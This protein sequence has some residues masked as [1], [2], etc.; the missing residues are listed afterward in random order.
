M[1]N[2][3][4]SSVVQEFEEHEKKERVV[5]GILGAF[6]GALIGCAVIL[7]IGHLGYIAAI[8]GVIMAICSVNGYRIFAGKM[9]NKGIFFCI[10]IMA[11]MVY[12]ANRLEYAL[13]FY[14]ELDAAYGD[15]SFIKV[16]ENL[17]ELLWDY[18]VYHSYI[19]DMI[20][21]YAFTGGGAFPTIKKNYKEADLGEFKS[22]AS[23]DAETET[24]EAPATV[25]AETSN[26]EV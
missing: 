2:F 17:N 9:S 21:L 14:R 26:S 19:T 3:N 1:E 5:L 18:D 23:D 16:Y 4:E 7:F 22:S 6:L 10:V 11:V 8:G 25:E 15:I 13:D 20:C 24:S 12:F